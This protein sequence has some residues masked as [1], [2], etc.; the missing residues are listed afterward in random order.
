M[1]ILQS[2]IVIA[3]CVVLVAVSADN[4]CELFDAVIVRPRFYPL[5]LSTP[6][7]TRI[8]KALL[9]VPALGLIAGIAGLVAPQLV[10]EQPT[11]HPLQRAC[12]LIAGSA[13]LLAIGY[14]IF[15]DDL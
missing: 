4:I 15:R 1:E 13:A 11:F 6:L 7:R 2:S 3:V 12:V 5:A 14:A 9:C 8:A 10:M